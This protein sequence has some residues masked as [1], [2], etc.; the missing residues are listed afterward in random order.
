[1]CRGGSRGKAIM[2]LRMRENSSVCRA[3]KSQSSS[4]QC[5]LSIQEAM[6]RCG[7]FFLEPEAIFHGYQVRSIL[8]QA[9]LSPEEVQ[10]A[11]RNA[12]SACPFLYWCDGKKGHAESAFRDTCRTS[13]E[14]SHP[15]PPPFLFFL[16]PPLMCYLSTCYRSI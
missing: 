8:V 11:S 14:L 2:A 9:E 4:C 12:D 13:S 7:S 16:D 3:M 10:H 15:P 5:L 6:S 1:M